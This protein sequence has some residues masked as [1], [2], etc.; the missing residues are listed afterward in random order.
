MAVKRR[1]TNCTKLEKA[2]ILFFRLA[3]IG[4]IAGFS[5]V[6]AV[7]AISGVVKAYRPEIGETR[8]AIPCFLSFIVYFMTNLSIKAAIDF[9]LE[10]RYV[11]RKKV[12]KRL[13]LEQAFVYLGI[14]LF[15]WW[16]IYWA[17]RE[18]FEYLQIG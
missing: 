11:R 9:L 1:K 6:V 3:W 8:I 10:L 12:T 18:L 15:C 7:M 16:V 5:L 13:G 4:G 2:S 14:A 17:I